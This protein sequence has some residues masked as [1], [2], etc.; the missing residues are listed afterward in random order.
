MLLLALFGGW[1]EGKGELLR[2]AQAA[3]SH[4]GA[5]EKERHNAFHDEQTKDVVIDV[6]YHRLIG[7]LPG[8]T[9]F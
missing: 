4:S 1:G 5:K 6:F 2:G 3:R 8:R 7:S 9:S